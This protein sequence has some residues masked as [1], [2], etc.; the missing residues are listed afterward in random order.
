MSVA[1]RKSIDG[2]QSIVQSAQT[3]TDRKGSGTKMRT[4]I[5]DAPNVV[6]VRNNLFTA[7]RIGMDE[8][9]QS[10]VHRAEQG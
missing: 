7:R 3:Q 4:E 10:S 5:I 1:R 8:V 9:N 2:G 6:A